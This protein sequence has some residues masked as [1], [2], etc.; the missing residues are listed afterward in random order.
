MRHLP[1]AVGQGLA[2]TR[3]A[4]HR[5][6]DSF[7]ARIGLDNT[8]CRKG[9]QHCCHYPL[10]ISVWEGLSLY[11]ALKEEGLWRPPLK[12]ALERHSALTFGTAPEVWLLAGIPCPLLFEGTCS[13]Y[14]HRP[15]RCRVTVSTRDPDLCRAVYFGPHTFES[16]QEELSEFETVEQR[17]GKAS[18]DFVRGMDQHVPLSTAVLIGHQ[19]AEEEIALEEVPRTLLSFLGQASK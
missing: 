12:L 7:T 8:T 11:Q 9:C 1:L 17:A 14:P 13:S 6:A 4:K 3:L 19:I 18:R 10:S 2:S 15:L 5:L 16:N